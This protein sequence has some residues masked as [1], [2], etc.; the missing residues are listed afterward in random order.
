MAKQRTLQ[1]LREAFIGAEGLGAAAV[2]VR[3]PQALALLDCAAALSAAKSELC[4]ANCPARTH[5]DECTDAF[6]ALTK[7]KEA[8]VTI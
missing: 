3:V 5:V 6:N 8:G 1:Q 4:I 2:M 7:L